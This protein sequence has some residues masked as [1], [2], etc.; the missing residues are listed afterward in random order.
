MSPITE[1][2]IAN[3]LVHTPDFF[4]RHAEILG[5]IRLSSPHGNRAVSLQERQAEMMR[6][7]IRGLELRIME[8][9][10]NGGDYSL[11]AQ[12]LHKWTMGLLEVNKAVDIP[13]AL[14]KGLE[15]CFDIPQA[16]IKVWDVSKAA[17]KEPFAK[18]VSEDVQTFASTLLRP[19]C[20]PN[21]GFE[22]VSWLERP[23]EV[24]SLALI[25]LHA[26]T[27]TSVTPIHDGVS[28]QN[29]AIGLLV[30][31]SDS[32]QRFNA[33]MGTVFLEQIGELA[34]ASLARLRA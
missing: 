3:F 7:K 27:D 6:E 12:H 19:Y 30:L 26:P 11:I 16:A 5:T 10:R 24:K 17:K 1:D 20:G 8:M 22:A 34:S 31:A 13:S 32:E 4:V 29:P 28:I 15:K 33:E 25:A 23:D 2:D 9:M 18:G 14:V 21:S